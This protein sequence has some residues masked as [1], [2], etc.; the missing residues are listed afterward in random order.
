[1]LK[2]IGKWSHES[3][4]I[5]FPVF[6]L[7]NLLSSWSKQFDAMNAAWRCAFSQRVSYQ[8]SIFHGAATTPGLGRRSVANPNPA[9]LFGAWHPSPRIVLLV[10][11]DIVSCN[12]SLSAVVVFGLPQSR[13]A[14]VSPNWLASRLLGFPPEHLAEFVPLGLCVASVS[15]SPRGYDFLSEMKLPNAQV[16]VVS[17]VSLTLLRS[18]N[19]EVSFWYATQAWALASWVTLPTF[20]GVSNGISR[21]QRAPLLMRVPPQMRQKPGRAA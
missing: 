20:C 1:M 21:R 19:C 4:T 15:N 12:F 10:P 13:S 14:T 17:I 2:Q 11:A 5:H 8:F 3:R 6:F 18:S 7:K 16:L 9:E